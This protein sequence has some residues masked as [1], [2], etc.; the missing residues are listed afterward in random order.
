MDYMVAHNREPVVKWCKQPGFF[1]FSFLCKSSERTLLPAVTSVWASISD[2]LSHS[3][4]TFSRLPGPSCY[5]SRYHGC[6]KNGRRAGTAGMVPLC[7]AF[8]AALPRFLPR[9]REQHDASVWRRLHLGDWPCAPV[10]LHPC[11]KDRQPG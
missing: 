3:S 5:S 6:D 4:V 2:S 8:Q 11:G 9:A 7:N 1:F 10:P